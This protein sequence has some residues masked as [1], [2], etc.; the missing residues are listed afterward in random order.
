MSDDTGDKRRIVVN[1][2]C[3]VLAVVGLGLVS[4]RLLDMA[5][6]A[7]EAALSVDERKEKAQRNNAEY[8]ETYGSPK[9]DPV[10]WFSREKYDCE[11]KVVIDEVKNQIACTGLFTCSIHG[12]ANLS[13]VEAAG[14][15][16]IKSRIE[17]FRDRE[18]KTAAKRM[19]NPTEAELKWS[20]RMVANVA[21]DHQSVL[22]TFPGLFKNVRSA[23]SDFN[24]NIS[25]YTCRMEFQYDPSIVVPLWRM[26]YRADALRDQ[27]ALFL[28]NEQ[29]KKDPNSDYISSLTEAALRMNGI[30]E[31]AQRATK[32]AAT[33]TVQ[34]S[35]NQSFVVEVTDIPLPGE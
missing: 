16:G 22:M 33:F 24:P 8:A 32:S 26:K 14:P 19:T 18:N 27:N 17:S 3:L 25:K 4:N 2:A 30:P 12:F 9:I 34:P 29:L 23:A 15:A 13:E 5:G 28:A 10:S 31:K 21:D 35:K 7:N 11:N 1:G 6:A 20:A